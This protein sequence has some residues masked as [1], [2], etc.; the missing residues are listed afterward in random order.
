VGP[1][2]TDLEPGRNLVAVVGIAAVVILESV[3]L[4][5]GID[6]QLFATALGTVT[7]IVGYVFGYSRASK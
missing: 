1:N 7:L 5:A 6:G 3:A 2:L 4:V